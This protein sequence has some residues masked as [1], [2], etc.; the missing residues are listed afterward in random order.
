MS[1]DNKQEIVEKVKKLLA[2]AQSSNEHEAKLAAERATELLTK[3]NLTMDDVSRKGITIEHETRRLGRRATPESKFILSLL[4]EFFFVH[5]VK[6]NILDTATFQFEKYFILLGRD[7]NVQIAAYVFDFLDRTFKN[8]FRDY[9]KANPKAKRQS[10][11]L[12]LHA[13]L[14]EHLTEVRKRVHASTGI[15]LVPVDAELERALEKMGVKRSKT[16]IKVDDDTA[17]V[18][19]IEQGR[20]IRIHGSVE[21]GGAT[22]TKSVGAEPRR[23]HSGRT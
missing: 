2:L 8:L 19:G 21:G 17:L 13:G 1:Q 16:R 10:F 23:I 15:A 7:H 9:K 14:H 12:G 4:E 3:H 6:T 20:K 22:N 18:A 5:P 11:Y